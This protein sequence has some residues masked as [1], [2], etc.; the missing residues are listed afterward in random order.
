MQAWPAPMGSAPW[1]ATALSLR[2]SGKDE[3]EDRQVVRSEV[4]EHV[5]VGL[6]QP[7][8]DPHGV[9][10]LDVAELACAD[11]L[12]RCAAPRACS[13]R[14][15]RTSGCAAPA[16]R[17]RASPPPPRPMPRAASRSGRACRRACSGCRDRRASTPASRLPPRG[18]P[19]RLAPRRGARWRAP[20]I[21][22]RQP[23]CP[24][25]VE[26]ADPAEFRLRVEG[27][28][29]YQVW[30][31]VPGSEYRD[32]YPIHQIYARFPFR[33]LMD[34]GTLMPPPG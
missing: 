4:P 31:P 28:V 19:D 2:S 10:E 34:A 26:V 5:D 32:A 13:S 3:V 27:N 15:G 33:V 24:F 25:D 12:A 29:A 21:G 1:A 30:S 8:V 7:E 16:R 20:R 18:R 9:D 22:I 6:D 23:S 14:C 17:R 11:Q